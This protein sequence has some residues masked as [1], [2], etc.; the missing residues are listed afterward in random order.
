[1]AAATPSQPQRVGPLAARLASRR[2]RSV[3][4]ASIAIA[5]N[6]AGSSATKTR[7]PWSRTTSRTAVETIGLPPAMYSRVFVGLIVLVASF[8][9]HG[10]RQTSNDFR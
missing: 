6:C 9:A 2:R 4:A 8:S 1:M 7:S 5:T 10:I 3:D